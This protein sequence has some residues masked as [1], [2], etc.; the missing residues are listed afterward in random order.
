MHKTDFK[1]FGLKTRSNTVPP[2]PPASRRLHSGDHQHPL[3]TTNK[4]DH[5]GAR[6]LNALE[7]AG[8]KIGRRKVVSGVAVRAALNQARSARANIE[9]CDN[10]GVI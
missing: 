10:K 5:F 4:S 3:T 7:I 1:I 6:L 2:R 9:M 8:K